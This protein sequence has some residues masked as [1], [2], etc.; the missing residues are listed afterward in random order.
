MRTVR[1]V[2]T[3]I[4]QTENVQHVECNREY[5]AEN[6]RTRVADAGNMRSHAPDRKSSTEKVQI[7]STGPLL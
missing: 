5:S 7:H 6:S 2:T 3:S 4:K 1:A